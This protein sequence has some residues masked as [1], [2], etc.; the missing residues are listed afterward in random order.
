MK[1][2]Q[3]SWSTSWNTSWSEHIEYREAYSYRGKYYRGAWSTC[4]YN[5]WSPKNYQRPHIESN[6]AIAVPSSVRMA[7]CM[8]FPSMLVVIVKFKPEDK[9]MIEIGPEFRS[10]W[11]RGVLAEN[12]GIYCV[13]RYIGP[14]NG[15]RILKID[16]IKMSPYPF[17]MWNFQRPVRNI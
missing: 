11:S 8:A 14:N 15:G 3:P 12:G 10:T 9:T 7:V 1:L 16:T 17:F 13:A 4:K 2:I 6:H 5:W